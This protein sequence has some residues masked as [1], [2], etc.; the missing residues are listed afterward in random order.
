MTPIVEVEHLK[1]YFPTGR[2]T[3]HAVD[4]VSFSIE[5]GTTL[6]LVGESGCGKSTLGRTIIHLL[7]STD[8][9]IRFQGKDV[10]HVKGRKLSDLRK[11]MQI[12]FQDPYTSLNPRLSVKD[13]IREP[14][15]LSKRFSSQELE[16]EVDRLMD[17]VGVEQR[18][19]NSY[20]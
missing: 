18:L 20:L 7:E 8:G 4:D 16:K 6:G 15:M 2:G 9:I 17:L 3:V 19:R 1:K 14:L 5:Q 12:I 13:T 10:T 11:D